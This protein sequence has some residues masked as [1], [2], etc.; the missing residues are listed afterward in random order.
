MYIKNIDDEISFLN[1]K[2]SKAKTAAT[3]NKKD[4]MTDTTYNKILKSIKELKKRKIAIQMGL[5]IK[6][7]QRIQKYGN[8]G[9]TQY[10]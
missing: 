7:E 3:K 4:Y 5:M 9:R 1:K 6:H 10:C 8:N 2:L